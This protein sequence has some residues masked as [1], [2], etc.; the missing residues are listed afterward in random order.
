MIDTLALLA[1]ITRALSDSRPFA[2]RLRDLFSVIQEAI[3][4]RDARLT[5]WFESARPGGT[6]RHF[7]S[8]GGWQYPWDESLTRQVALRRQFERSEIVLGGTGSDERES[9]LPILQATYLGAPIIWGD[10]LW[11]VLELRVTA[12]TPEGNSPVSAESISLIVAI[13]PQLA[14]AISQEGLR[15]QAASS[16]SSETGLARLGNLTLQNDT[17]LTL[18]ASRSFVVL[19]RALAEV[20]SLDAMLAAILRCALD[21]T[22]AEAGAISMVDRKRGELVLQAYEGYND[23]KLPK[24]GSAPRWSWNTGI[25]GKVARSG[26]ATLLRDV[27]AESEQSAF[28]PY[29]LAVAAQAELAAPIN[30]EGETLAV[31]VLDS[32]R[33]DAFN[34]ASLA[35]VRNLCDRSGRPLRR[36]LRHQ[37]ELEASMQISQVF[38][39]LPIAVAL[40]D[41]NGRVLRVNPAWFQV[42]GLQDEDGNDLFEIGPG[43][44]PFHIPIDLLEALLSRL[45]EPRQLTDFCS[46]A[47]RQSGETRTTI[48]RLNKPNRDIQIL[49]APTYDREGQVVGLLWAVS[50]VT[51]EREADRLKSEFVAVVSHELRTP[52][53]SILGYTELLLEREFEPND[54]REFVQTVYNQAN[55]LSQ[56]VEDLLN[57]SRIDSGQIRLSR[58]V[59]NLV[60]LIRELPSQL[61][62]EMGDRMDT[63]RLVLAPH[64][65][66]PLVYADRDKLRQII[67]NLL[68][69]AVKYSPNGGQVVLEAVEL[70]VPNEFT[71]TPRQRTGLT[72]PGIARLSPLDGFKL[73]MDHPAGSWVMVSV[74]DEGLGISPE[75]QLHIWERFY[76]VDNT[77]TRRIGG[78]GLGLSIT[79]AL[80][81]LHGGRIWVESTLGEGSTFSFT[82]PVA[83]DLLIHS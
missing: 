25:A 55:H 53:T 47:Q 9:K 28:E 79:K 31:I 72:P 56:L 59:L 63:H 65:P 51:R 17:P 11:G 44:P 49:E 8:P 4:Y 26:R 50:D 36:M 80:V 24:N 12:R 15:L 67:F 61:N 35:F 74:R 23:I 62:K 42:W 83:T 78:T 76:R 39:N 30:D 81:E 73:P 82:L 29:G 41:R 43:S 68:T 57:A 7:Y 13:L 33:S 10:K 77:N 46:A 54:R 64:E 60:Q 37:A 27:S 70:R 32:P 40:I 3:P 21:V 58:R 14:A 48:I 69:N 20:E 5:C 19:E 71:T 16:Q 18:A 22:G 2:A 6:R 38:N 52:L 75:D 45:S 34:E 1:A 66:L